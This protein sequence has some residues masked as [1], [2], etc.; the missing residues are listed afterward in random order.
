VGRT[1][2]LCELKIGLF[3]CTNLIVAAGENRHDEF[4]YLN[5]IT[6]YTCLGLRLRLLGPT[7]SVLR[8][9]RPPYPIARHTHKARC[10]WLKWLSIFLCND[11]YPA[12]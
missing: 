2:Y 4:E 9:Q 3:H 7:R 6:I 12:D 10:R 11:Y 1:F 5:D 8:K